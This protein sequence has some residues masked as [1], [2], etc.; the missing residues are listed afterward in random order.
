MSRALASWPSSMKAWSVAEIEPVVL[1]ADVLAWRNEEGGKRWRIGQW[2]T[3]VG[4]AFSL[5]G[6]GAFG[7]T[8]VFRLRAGGFIRANGGGLPRMS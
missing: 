2:Y 5:K 8:Q 1:N 3:E 4:H 7:A 6:R